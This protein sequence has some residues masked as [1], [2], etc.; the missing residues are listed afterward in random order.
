MHIPDGFLSTPVW[1]AFD[2][3]AVPVVGILA[4]RAQRDMEE[5][6]IPLMGVMGAFIFAA[7]MI[8]FP[9]G[10]GTSGH[11]VGGTLLAITLG[12]SA[13]AIVMT[14]ILAIQAL[15]FQDGGI[16]AL[17]ANVFNMAIAGVL[18]GYLPYRLLRN[19]AGIFIGGVLSVLVSAGFALA[20]LSVSGIPFPPR[21]LAITLSFFAVGAILEGAITLA[22]IRAVE[23]LNPAWIRGAKEPAG[24]ALIVVGMAA[25]ILAVAGILIASTHPDGIEILARAHSPAWLH[26]PLADYE[27]HG[28][29]TPWLRK[30][31][32]G[33]AGLILIYAACLAAGRWIR[34]RNA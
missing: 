10:P 25:V 27:A 8:N 6:S 13:A 20:Q 4:R 26:A 32:A 24:R 29:A 14:A 30:S 31:I 28:I 3:A 22:A 33:L 15:V 19:S 9:V 34:Q 18:A 1:V 23:R 7:Q 5:R 12:P 17:G 2:L 11:L 16:L 21:V